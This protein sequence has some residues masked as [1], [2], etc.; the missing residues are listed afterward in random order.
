MIPLWAVQVTPLQT[1]SRIKLP[2]DKGSWTC[3]TWTKASNHAWWWWWSV[4]SVAQSCP[5]LRPHESQ[6][7]RPPCTSP[8]PGVYP[9]SC[10]LRRW[11]HLTISS[12]VVPFSSSLQSFPASGSFQI[13]QLFASGGQ[14][15]GSFSF[16]II[17]SNEYPGPTSFRMD[18]L[19]LLTVQGTLKSLLPHHSSKASVFLRSAWDTR[20]SQ[21]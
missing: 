18:W 7:A 6:H 4:S 20:H 5:A 15:I 17:P 16:S 21:Q 2:G 14:N 3:W 12:S 13:S 19:D 1:Q 8:T 9:N 10:P 11:C